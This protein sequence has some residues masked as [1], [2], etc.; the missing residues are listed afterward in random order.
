MLSRAGISGAFGDA[1]GR[2]AVKGRTGAARARAFATVRSSLRDRFV[3]VLSVCAALGVA[4]CR[5]PPASR[6]AAFVLSPTIA[7]GVAAARVA[8]QT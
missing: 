5:R 2:S 8:A 6:G 1:A 7:E 3:D 4:G